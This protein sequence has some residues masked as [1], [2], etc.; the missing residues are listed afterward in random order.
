MRGLYLVLGMR[1]LILVI[2]L[3]LVGCGDYEDRFDALNGQI[4]DIGSGEYIEDSSTISGNNDDNRPENSPYSKRRGIESSTPSGDGENND[5]SGGGDLSSTMDESEFIDILVKLKCGSSAQLEC[6]SSVSGKIEGYYNY[7]FKDLTAVNT[8]SF[9]TEFDRLFKG[10]PAWELWAGNTIKDRLEFLFWEHGKYGVSDFGAFYENLNDLRGKDGTKAE[11]EELIK[12]PFFLGY[13]VWYLEKI[14][15]NETYKKAE[16][17]GVLSTCYPDF[18][19]G[20]AKRRLRFNSS[21]EIYCTSSG[22]GYAQTVT[23][24]YRFPVETLYFG[25]DEAIFVSIDKLV[26]GLNREQVDSFNGLLKDVVDIVELKENADKGIDFIKK[27]IKE[28]KTDDEY[29]T[30]KDLEEKL[31]LVAKLISQLD[32]VIKLIRDAGQEWDKEYQKYGRLLYTQLPTS[33]VPLF[34]QPFIVMDRNDSGGL[35]DYFIEGQDK[36]TIDDG[37]V[38]FKQD[39]KGASAT[40][41][42]V[43]F[44]RDKEGNITSDI[45]FGFK[46]ND[47]DSRNSGVSAKIGW[48]GKYNV[49]GHGCYSFNKYKENEGIEITSDTD[50]LGKVFTDLLNKLV[51][52]KW[53]QCKN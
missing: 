7:F 53:S 28:L 20:G 9:E 1:E 10:I 31:D 33:K 46:S 21:E 47:S 29:N 22:V 39:K 2:V 36:V 49:D 37:S 16:S 4:T 43:Y 35:T 34:E 30:I 40:A 26:I 51:L 52:L 5:D 27:K 25:L 6:I 17:S 41:G 11:Y 50:Q 19:T 24:E 48:L 8:D 12:D 44:T 38:I 45:L 15:K 32:T 42:D 18:T 14:V 13:Y 23:A 3:V